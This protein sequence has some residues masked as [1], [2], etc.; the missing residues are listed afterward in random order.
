[1]IEIALSG[2]SGLIALID[3]SDYALVSPLRWY[4]LRVK[5]SKT[6]YARA[7]IDG[8]T[9]YMHRLIMGN[10]AGMDIDHID[11][12]GLNNQRANLQAVTH[13]QNIL[14]GLVRQDIAAWRARRAT[15]NTI[16]VETG[17]KPPQREYR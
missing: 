11:F 3:D 17:C 1:M 2:N 14:Q 16:K 10:P 15:R 5:D 4:H 6:V 8:R 9:V 13:Q 7:N 12:N